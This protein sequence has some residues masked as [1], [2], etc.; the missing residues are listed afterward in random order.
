MLPHF[1]T[2]VF[3]VIWGILLSSSKVRRII[4]APSALCEPY[5]AG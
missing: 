3:I 5:E 2:I 4:G 1:S